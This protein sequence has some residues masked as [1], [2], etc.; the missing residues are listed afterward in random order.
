LAEVEPDTDRT[1]QSKNDSIG[2]KGR[3]LHGKRHLHLHAHGPADPALLAAERGIWAVKISFFALLATALVQVA[4]VFFSGSMA[5]LADTVHNLGDALTAVP[6]WVAFRLGQRPATD[7]FT[8][9]YGRAEDLVGLFIV[10]V[11]VASGLFTGYEVGMRLF[12]PRPVG[13]IW[14]V[15]LASVIGFLGNEAVAVFRMRVGREIGSAALVADGHHARADGLTSLA[16]LVGAVGVWAGYPRADPL[17]G[18]LIAVAILRIGWSSGRV[19]LTRLIDGVDPGV[20]DEVRDA[21]DRAAGVEEVAGVKVRWLGHRLHAEIDVIV[22]PDLTVE[23]GH[24]IAKEVG[25]QLLHSLPYLSD[26]TVHVD[27]PRAPG[28]AYH[29]IENHRHDDLRE[30]SHL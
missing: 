6:L 30:H 18:F 10:L 17:V 19:V 7:R 14:A 23:E 4:I 26:A 12:H 1:M 16:V 28:E 2:S 25:H 11:I 27:P 29:W 20:V 24:D 9:G 13:F 21:A 3:F 8:Y 15:I 22:D 5:L